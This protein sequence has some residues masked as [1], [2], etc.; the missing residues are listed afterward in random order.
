MVLACAIGGALVLS[1]QHLAVL[2]IATALAG[3]VPDTIEIVT[4]FGPNGERRSLLPHRTLSHSP[5][6]YV[7]LLIGGLWL[8]SIAGAVVGHLLA[9]LGLGGLVHL[10]VDLLSPA[11][12]PLANPFGTRTSVG[13]YRSGG[14]FPYL[15]RTSTIEEWPVIVP[16]AVLLVV[17][18]V[19]AG[20]T[21]ASG[22]NLGRLLA[23]LADG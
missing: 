9:G 22:V 12:V 19:L 20:A 3:R 5:Y 11:G 2:G 10:A 4:G 13:P 8:P 17:E 7:A 1:R 16:F 18:G 23:A 15:Y 6:P 21:I 14:R